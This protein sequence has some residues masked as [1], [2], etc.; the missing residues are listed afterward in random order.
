MMKIAPEFVAKRTPSNMKLAELNICPLTSALALSAWFAIAL[1][2]AL[3]AEPALFDENAPRKIVTKRALPNMK[4]A[5]L[6]I[7]VHSR[8]L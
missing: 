5:E 3:N 8:A 1:I 4:L 6:N 2:I 7:S